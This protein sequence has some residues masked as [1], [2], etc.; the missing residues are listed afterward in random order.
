MNPPP[1]PAPALP[2]AVAAVPA[3]PPTLEEQVCAGVCCFCILP[4]LWLLFLVSAWGWDTIIES[5]VIWGHLHPATKV[6]AVVTAHNIHFPHICPNMAMVNDTMQG[7][8]FGGDLV[9]RYLDAHGANQTCSVFMYHEKHTRDTVMEGMSAYPV[10]QAEELYLIHHG[11]KGSCYWPRTITRWRRKAER[12]GVWNWKF[13]LFSGVPC[14]LCIGGCL[15]AL[16][17]DCVMHPELF[18]N[19]QQYQ[20]VPVE[21]DAPDEEIDLEAGAEAVQ[22]DSEVEMTARM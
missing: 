18:F 20:A 21:E 1:A 13:V 19:P 22:L 5:Q 17:W 16:C 7:L 4:L 15:F 12:N 6:S 11:K 8:C 14:W 2:A 9:F 3:T 10:G